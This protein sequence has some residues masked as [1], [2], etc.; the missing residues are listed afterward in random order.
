MMTG[1]EQSSLTQ[2]NFTNNSITWEVTRHM[3]KLQCI[4]KRWEVTDS[5]AVC[6]SYPN[7]KPHSLQAWSTPQLENK[8][9]PIIQTRV[10]DQ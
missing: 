4:G 9:K 3:E 2:Q 1:L 10:G 8:E 7:N 6:K 5:Q